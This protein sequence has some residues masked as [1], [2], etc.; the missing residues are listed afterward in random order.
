MNFFQTRFLKIRQLAEFCTQKSWIWSVT[1][2]S[3]QISDTSQHDDSW[4]LLKK[5]FF[6]F[7]PIEVFFEVQKLGNFSKLIYMFE[8][9]LKKMLLT[10]IEFLHS[11]K[12]DKLSKSA[13]CVKYPIFVLKIKIKLWIL[14]IFF[15]KSIK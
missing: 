9:C 7:K 6:F 10:T 15:S 4:S 1:I 11:S 13:Q 5:A 3:V 2:F 8:W 14:F 12:S